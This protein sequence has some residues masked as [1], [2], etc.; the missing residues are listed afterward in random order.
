M[1][2]NIVPRDLFD[3][4]IDCDLLQVIFMSFLFGVTLNS[5]GEQRTPI[6]RLV[7]SLDTF[8]LRVLTK[9]VGLMPLI[10][11]FAMASLMFNVGVETLL[12]LARGIFAQAL[13]LVVVTMIYCVIIRLIGRQ[14][15]LPFL[16]KII[17]FVPV[18][19]ALAST[20]ATMPYSLKFCTEKLGV[21]EKLSAFALPIGASLK[22]D[23]NC[24]YFILQTVMLTKLYGIELTYEM[25]TMLVTFV[26]MMSLGSP[27][28]T[29]GAVIVLTSIVVAVGV[30]MEAIGIVLSI[31]ALLTLFRTPLNVIGGIVATFV[32]AS[33]ESMIDK[34]VYLK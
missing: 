27:N 4:F 6:V 2:V 28:V 10:A 21:D 9:I 22:L 18:P 26:L 11:F 19:M 34:A 25:L 33:N 23:G 30:P 32:L 17:P 31:D 1:L 7:R 20:N 14:S 24:A 5:L 3:P 15:S 13:M 29:G 12:I 8:F 16:K